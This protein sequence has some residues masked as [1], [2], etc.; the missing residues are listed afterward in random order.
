[1][2]LPFAQDPVSVGPHMDDMEVLLHHT[3]CTLD[4]LR[5]GHHHTTLVNQTLAVEVDEPSSELHV[6]T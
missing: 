5:I 4:D 1:M 2:P 3:Q 6:T